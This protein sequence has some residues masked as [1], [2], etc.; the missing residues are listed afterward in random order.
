MEDVHRMVRPLEDV[1]AEIE[2]LKARINFLEAHRHE[3]RERI[4]SLATH[5]DNRTLE[6]LPAVRTSR[7]PLRPS[8]S[9]SLRQAA[10]MVAAMGGEVTAEML[11]NKMSISFDAAR[12]R[13]ARAARKGLVMRVSLGK[14]RASDQDEPAHT[15]GIAHK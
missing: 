7:R 8:E 11:S 14:Y 6:L 4:T 15:N 9:L 10:D 12:L 1:V 5:T 3:L 13:L 2:A